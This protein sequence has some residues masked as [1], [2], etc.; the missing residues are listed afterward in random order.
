MKKVEDLKKIF[1]EVL[2]RNRDT[3]HALNF[4]LANHPEVSGE[5]YNSCKEYVRLCR[6]KGMETEENFC[7]LPTAFR[8]SAVRSEN[9]VARFALLAEY[10][11]LPQLGHGCGHSASGSL[12]LL[13]AF[14]LCDMSKE[15][16]ADV[17]LIGTPDE[18]LHGL[19]AEMANQGVF[20]DYDFAIMIHMNSDV[21]YPAID[22]LALG[23]YRV[24]FH[25]KT[26]HASASPWEGRNALNAAGLTV[27]ALDMMRQQV[28]PDTRISYYY[29]NGGEAS[30]V[31]PD[32]AELEILLR[33][34]KRS[35]LNEVAERMRNCVKG[36]CL[37]TGTAYEID[38]IGYEYSDM[39]QNE[40]G[41]QTIRSVMDELHVPYR[42]DDHTMLGSSDIGNVS[43]ECPAFSPIL[44]IS[45]RHFALHTQEVVDIMK[46]PKA[47]EIIDLGARIM[48]Y[49]VLEVMSDPKRLQKIKDEFNRGKEVYHE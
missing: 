36:A 20:K 45:D 14:A 10:D 38:T 13:T 44:A 5:E 30:N 27:H 40:V 16:S 46:S 32:Y 25:G 18:E 15:L 8:A 23:G 29:V 6:E 7:G 2:F 26:S 31:I 3:A 21:T 33:H 22:F 39:L 24:K 17:D 47:E 12:S 37:A 1:D 43:Y 19:K 42:E 35:Y 48:G 34:T 41:I 11:A 9:P 4:D 49:T 28:K